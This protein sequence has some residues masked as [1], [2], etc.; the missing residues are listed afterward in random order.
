MIICK[1]TEDG[2]GFV[3][4]PKKFDSTK[5]DKKVKIISNFIN[6]AKE[7]FCNNTKYSFDYYIEDNTNEN[8]I[9]LENIKLRKKSIISLFKKVTYEPLFLQLKTALNE[10]KEL[11]EHITLTLKDNKIFFFYEGEPEKVKLR[12]KLI[13]F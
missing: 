4:Q 6:L 9:I 7:L 11:K 8:F 13:D 1:I 3:S 5:E 12:N 2:I 10:N